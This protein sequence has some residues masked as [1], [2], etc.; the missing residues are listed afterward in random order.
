MQNVGNV[1]MQKDVYMLLRQKFLC[2]YKVT[3][4]EKDTQEK[5]HLFWFNKYIGW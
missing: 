5:T 2:T 1:E 4:G 3:H